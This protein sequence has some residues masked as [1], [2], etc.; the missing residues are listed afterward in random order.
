MYRDAHLNS[1]KLILTEGRNMLARASPKIQIESATSR[2]IN[3]HERPSASAPRTIAIAAPDEEMATII[4]V[5][6]YPYREGIV[7]MPAL[8]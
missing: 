5:C 4:L 7:G 2:R 6:L 8:A 3:P 1:V